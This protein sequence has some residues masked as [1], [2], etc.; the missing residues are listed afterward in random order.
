MYGFFAD[1][2]N[3][4]EKF[5][6]S[7]HKRNK[8]TY[9]LKEGLVIFIPFIWTIFFAF[10]RFAC[11]SSGSFENPLWHSISDMMI[12]LKDKLHYLIMHLLCM[13]LFKLDVHH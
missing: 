5:S 4:E 6:Y 9:I 12:Y 2:E 7:S 11:K 1:E 10:L 8:E 3:V 13:L